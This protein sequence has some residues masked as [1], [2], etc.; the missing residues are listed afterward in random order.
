MRISLTKSELILVGEEENVEEL[1][2]ELGCR[3]GR[4][5]FSYL[6][7]PLGARHRSRTVWNGVGERTRRRPMLWKRQYIS[8]GGRVALIKNT[9]ASM[10]LYLMPLVKRPKVVATLLE[11]IQRDFLW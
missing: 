11:K 4:F 7:F 5:P 3:V 10:S 6:G 1:A 9:L 8:K 2:P